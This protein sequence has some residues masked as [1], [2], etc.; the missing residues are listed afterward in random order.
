MNIGEK[1]RMNNELFSKRLKQLRKSLDMSQREFANFTG[2]RQASIPG[3]E[4]GTATP[5]LDTVLSISQKCNV[6]IDWLLGT[7][8]TKSEA[9]PIKTYKDVAI[10]IIELINADMSPD[11][12]SLDRVTVGYQT[13]YTVEA[14][15]VNA[16][17]KTEFSIS[18]GIPK[19]AGEEPIKENVLK[20][21]QNETFKKFIG[22]FKEMLNM[23]E[24][25]RIKQSVLDAWISSE[26]AEL[27]TININDKE[28][29]EERD[30]QQEVIKTILTSK[31]DTNDFKS[32]LSSVLEELNKQDTPPTGKE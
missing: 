32:Y 29:L 11:K 8:D 5:Q 2:I 12:F 18:S 1:E 25:G 27:D 30:I 7:S 20:L 3:Y 23:K 14:P 28:D 22:T 21:P 10:R 6:S 9:N 19:P 13:I 24:K 31:F 15:T 16:F 4:R 17:G 26:L